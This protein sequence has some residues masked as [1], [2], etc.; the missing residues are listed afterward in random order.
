MRVNQVDPSGK[1]LM[2]PIGLLLILCL[3]V[4][5]RLAH[6]APTPHSV[7]VLDGSLH[8]IEE[9]VVLATDGFSLSGTSTHPLKHAG[10]ATRVLSTDSKPL[11]D[12]GVAG[13]PLFQD[14]TTGL[15]EE[16]GALQKMICAQAL[17]RVAPSVS[18]IVSVPAVQP[19]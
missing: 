14:A 7:D 15:L 3:P 2:R 10:A 8:A 11:E 9:L 1:H 18:I 6:T 16:Y 13:N 4:A 19:H 5:V 17:R 12:A